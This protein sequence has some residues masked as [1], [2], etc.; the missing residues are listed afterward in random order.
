MTKKKQTGGEGGG[1]GE[2]MEGYVGGYGISRN[3]EK[4]KNHV[5]FLGVLVLGLT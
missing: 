2:D 1:G 4:E 3:Q 5:E